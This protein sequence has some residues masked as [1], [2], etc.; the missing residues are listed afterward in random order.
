[1]K[2]NNTDQQSRKR[3]TARETGPM[4]IGLD[5]GDKT[6]RYCVLDGAGGEQSEGRFY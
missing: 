2:K 6:S 5:L 3:A 1:M 4:T